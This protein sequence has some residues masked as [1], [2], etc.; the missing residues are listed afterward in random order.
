M[1]HTSIIIPTLN[2]AQTICQRAQELCA[3][4]EVELCIAD[5]GSTDGTR[6][7]LRTLAAQFNNV[8]WCDSERGRARQMN[9]AVRQA[10]GKWLIFL[11]ADTL[12]PEASLRG[13]LHLVEQHPHIDCGAFTFRVAHERLVYRYLE[14]YVAWRCRWLKLPFGDQAL[15]VR[16]DIFQ[17][18]GGY[19]EDFPLMEDVE[20][21]ERLNKRAG[22]HIAEFPVFTSARRFEADGYLRR[23]M[24]NL[25]LQMLYRFGVHPERLARRYYR[26]AA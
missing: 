5:G 12:L 16:R 22:F 2:E 11:H 4:P 18:Y 8:Q 3:L 26:K 23:S 15:F 13:F 10:H 17:E 19:R 20:L 9:A 24:G 14:W 7:H 25:V 21:V 6:E 1:P